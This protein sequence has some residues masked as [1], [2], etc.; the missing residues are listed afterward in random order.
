MLL[1]VPVTVPRADC[2]TGIFT[3]STWE[4]GVCALGLDQD[5][6]VVLSSFSQSHGWITHDSVNHGCCFVGVYM[7]VE[8][9]G[10]HPPRSI[11]GRS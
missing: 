5:H 10:H 2:A 4:L 7:T 8:G 9:Y 1:Q 6:L 11:S 3:D